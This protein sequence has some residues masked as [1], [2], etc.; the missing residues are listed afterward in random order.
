MPVVCAVLY[1]DDQFAE[2]AVASGELSRLLGQPLGQNKL[3]YQGT[4]RGRMY[5]LVL[6][7]HES[8]GDRFCDWVPVEGSKH[9]AQ[10][11]TLRTA[12][13]I[14]EVVL[15]R[16]DQFKDK[17]GQPVSGIPLRILTNMETYR[18]AVEATVK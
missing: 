14:C 7:G 15:G 10:V 8:M 16:A 13:Q 5:K 1:P 4:S 6:P 3:G 2:E 17:D 11:G 12:A 18:A 9:H